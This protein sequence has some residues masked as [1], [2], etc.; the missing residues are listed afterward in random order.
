MQARRLE[1]RHAQGGNPLRPP[2]AE[3][4]CP[5]PPGPSHPSLA[6]FPDPRSA[7]C[8]PPHLCRPCNHVGHKVSVAGRIQ[9]RHIA[10]RRLKPAARG[11]GGGQPLGPRGGRH[12]E[13]VGRRRRCWPVR[14]VPACM[15]QTGGRALR[16]AQQQPRCTHRVTATSTVTPLARSSGR[17]SS[18][19]AQAKEPLPLAAASRCRGGG[20]A[21]ACAQTMGGQATIQGAATPAA[22]AAAAAPCACCRL[23]AAFACAPGAPRLRPCQPS[24]PPPHVYTHTH[25]HTHR[26]T[27]TTRCAPHLR[28]VHRLVGHQA[29]LEQHAP[30]QRAL[31]RI[32]VTQHNQVQPRPGAAPGPLRRGSR[33]ARRRQLALWAVVAEG[34]P[35]WRRRRCRCCCSAVL[36]PLP[37]ANR[38]ALH[39]AGQPCG[40]IRRSMLLRLRLVLEGSVGLGR[41][42]RQAAAAA[43]RCRPCCCCRRRALALLR[44]QHNVIRRGPVERKRLHLPSCRSSGG[45]R[46]VPSSLWYQ[47][48]RLLLDL[49]R[50][51]QR[52]GCRGG[53]R[54]QGLTV[55]TALEGV[56]ASESRAASSAAQGASKPRRQAAYRP[57]AACRRGVW[58]A[59]PPAHAPAQRHLLGRLVLPP[60]WVVLAWR[61]RAVAQAGGAALAWWRR[62]LTHRPGCK[63][64]LPP[65]L[66]RLFVCYCSLC[67]GPGCRTHLGWL[68]R[69]IV[70]V[71]VVVPIILIVQIVLIPILVV[72]PAHPASSAECCAALL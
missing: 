62:R 24:T 5:E 68:R 35:R 59:G 72:S 42:R 3:Q 7:R 21:R 40:G 38:Q 37:L 51:G 47:L 46:A 55:F 27:H 64:A 67:Q 44:R 14:R 49:G 48:V 33:G 57:A 56:C 32:H 8:S 66:H 22:A 12:R 54:G 13:H 29:Q 10:P 53:E 61:R 58:A 1:E 2:C 6:S 39:A 4:V 17:S 43:A 71:L 15:P 60:G 63:P 30:H 52:L 18:I 23:A 28:L 36:L 69:S 50:L 41:L 19:Q 9:Q 16:P 31:P 20:A 25:T 70:E 26:V 65:S 11:G 34:P 45:G